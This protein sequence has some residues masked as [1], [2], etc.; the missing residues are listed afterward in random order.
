MSR[1]KQEFSKRLTRWVAVIF[2][3]NLAL[4]YIFSFLGKDTSLFAYSIPITGGVFGATVVFYLN[5]AKTEN[6]CK[7]KIK[8]LR[9]KLKIL[10]KHPDKQEVIE[11]EL[12]SIEDALNEKIDS[13]IAE[14]VSE[15]VE[16]QNY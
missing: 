14:A 6:V 4:G 10:D 7:G 9:F 15:S 3:A 1:P 12:A 13:E 5:K 11:D 8:F 16:T 2:V